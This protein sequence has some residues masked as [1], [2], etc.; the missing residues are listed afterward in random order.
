MYAGAWGVQHGDQRVEPSFPDEGRCDV[1][2]LAVI[3]GAVGER[4]GGSVE[5]GIGYGILVGFHPQDF[6]AS[7]RREIEMGEALILSNDGQVPHIQ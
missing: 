1:L 4:V 3:E 6:T 7:L 2:C 5:F